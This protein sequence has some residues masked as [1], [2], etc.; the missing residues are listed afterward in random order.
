[1]PQ[2]DLLFDRAPDAASGSCPRSAAI[3]TRLAVRV[4]VTS[5][6]THSLIGANISQYVLC[7]SPRRAETGIHNL[8]VVFSY[9]KKKNEIKYGTNQTHLRYGSKKYLKTFP[10]S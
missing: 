1:M 5:L 3:L 4:L 10:D 2:T 9:Q 8:N 7:T 6:R